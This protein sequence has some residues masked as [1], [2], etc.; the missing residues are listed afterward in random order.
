MKEKLLAEVS[1]STCR[2]CP[3]KQ[4]G[5][6]NIDAARLSAYLAAVRSSS[7]AT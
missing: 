5:F 7:A 1:T 6:K 3:S 4:K 2:L